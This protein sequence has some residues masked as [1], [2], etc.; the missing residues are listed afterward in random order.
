MD[1]HPIKNRIE[2]VAGKVKELTGK[3][4]G[5]KSLE[6]KGTVEKNDGKNRR[7]D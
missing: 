3:V 4:L 6:R 7:A 2:E 1:T 5:D